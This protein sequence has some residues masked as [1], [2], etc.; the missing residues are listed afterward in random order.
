M[1]TDIR[2]N[3]VRRLFK[4]RFSDQQRTGDDVLA[5][6]GF[7]FEQRPD[8]CQSLGAATRISISNLT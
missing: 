1:E 2:R 4:E 7:L 8:C 6:S 3:S 5:F